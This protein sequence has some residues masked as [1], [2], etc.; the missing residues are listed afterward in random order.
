MDEIKVDQVKILFEEVYC[1]NCKSKQC[2]K[3]QVGKSKEH[4]FNMVKNV[5]IIND[6][7]KIL[8]PNK[9]VDSE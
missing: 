3:C 2:Y 9:E 4:F 6:L 8:N 7:D 1:S 5:A